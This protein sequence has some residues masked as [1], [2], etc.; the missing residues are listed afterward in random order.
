MKTVNKSFNEAWEY[1]AIHLPSGFFPN[2]ESLDIS[3]KP[4]LTKEEWKNFVNALANVFL[5]GIRQ[6][7]LHFHVDGKGR[8]AYLFVPKQY[9]SGEMITPE[10]PRGSESLHI[11]GGYIKEGEK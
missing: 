2:G 7:W 1:L 4:S 10:V 9:A 3:V 6:R 5:I 8:I 11:E